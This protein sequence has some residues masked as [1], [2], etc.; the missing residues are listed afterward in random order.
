MHSFLSGRSFLSGSVATHER[1][2]LPSYSRAE[3]LSGSGRRCSSGQADSQCIGSGAGTGTGNQ[4][5]K[6]KAGVMGIHTVDLRL[7]GFPAQYGAHGCPIASSLL[8]FQDGLPGVGSAV[9][10]MPARMAVCLLI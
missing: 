10:T 2:R 8:A 9:T 5:E 6:I 3:A 1:I 4:K 7:D